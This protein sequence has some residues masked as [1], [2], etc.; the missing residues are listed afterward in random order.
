MHHQPNLQPRH[1]LPEQQGQNQHGSAAAAAAAA[2]RVAWGAV[3]PPPPP[4]AP[5]L[6]KA[7]IIGCALRAFPIEVVSDAFTTITKMAASLPPG[8][9]TGFDLVGQ[10][11]PG[12]PLTDF[13]PM[14]LEQLHPATDLQPLPFFFHAGETDIVGGAADLNL[15][16]AM[17][18]NTSRIGHGYALKQHP[19]L[20]ADVKQRGVAIEVCPISNQVLKLVDD[21][22]NHPLHAYLSEGLPVVLSPDDPALWGAHAAS[23]DWA[24]AYYAMDERPG[25][26]ATLKQLAINSIEHSTLDLTSKAAAMKAW[27]VGWKDYVEWLAALPLPQSPTMDDN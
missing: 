14:F 5:W 2:S 20:R 17:L 21:L 26:L 13:V 4:S 22:R 6:G 23:Y 27:A 8:L 16:D 25:G 9:I 1:Q 19:L 10:E 24:V 3:L 12:R 18:L 7:P 11:D 15:V